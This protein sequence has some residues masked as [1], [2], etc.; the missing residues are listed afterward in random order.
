MPHDWFPI[1]EM[2]DTASRSIAS[3]KEMPQHNRLPYYLNQGA[4][5]WSK[6]GT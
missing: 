4:Q 5:R 1:D 6:A 2:T 3:D